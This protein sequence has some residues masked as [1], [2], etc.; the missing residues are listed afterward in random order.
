M[1]QIQFRR[2]IHA[3]GAPKKP[4]LSAGQMIALGFGAVILLGAVLL[5]LPAAQQPGV[6]LT[7]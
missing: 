4:G 1:Q 5:Y 7:L 2:D 6:W 3:L